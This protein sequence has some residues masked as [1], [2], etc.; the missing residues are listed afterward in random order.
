MSGK[1]RNFD[2]FRKERNAK[3]PKFTLFD[4]EWVLPPTLRYDGVLAFQ[5]LA[6][7]DKS[8]VLSDEDAFATF[9][10]VLGPE[11]FNQLRQFTEFDVELAAEVTAWALAA[12]GLKSET[13]EVS[14][15]P[16]AEDQA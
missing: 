14:D 11:I 2:E 4:R 9:E 1:I 12:Y 16:K 13:E 8:E 6:K 5:R 7:R 3:A 10:A 15:G